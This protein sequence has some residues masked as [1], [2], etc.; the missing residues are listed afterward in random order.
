MSDHHHRC[1][2]DCRRPRRRGLRGSGHRQRATGHRSARRIGQVL[3]GA[4]APPARCSKSI[5]RHDLVLVGQRRRLVNVNVNSDR[6]SR[7]TSRSDPAQAAGRGAVADDQK[8][9]PAVR[10]GRCAVQSRHEMAMLRSPSRSGPGRTVVRAG[11][12]GRR[13]GCRRTPAPTRR[14]APGCRLVP[15][16]D[17]LDRLQV[18]GDETS[19][20]ADRLDAPVAGRT[21]SRRPTSGRP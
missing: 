10:T 11:G 21:G 14:P 15:C 3:D 5:G 19:R 8:S 16:A 9:V 13:R 17:E 12:D 2:G 4:G 20:P 6:A 18:A 7:P 1:R